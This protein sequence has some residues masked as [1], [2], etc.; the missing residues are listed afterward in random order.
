MPNSCRAGL[1]T[2]WE[3]L[4]LS[5]GPPVAQGDN[6]ASVQKQ[7]VFSTAGGVCNK[8]SILRRRKH[9]QGLSLV[10]FIRSHVDPAPLFLN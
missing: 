3:C 6:T 8:E 9:L 5:C 1:E 7:K 10:G 2:S 4:P